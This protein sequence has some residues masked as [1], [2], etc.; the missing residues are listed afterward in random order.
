MELTARNTIQPLGER[1]WVLIYA[2]KIMH[3]LAE[4]GHEHGVVRS[5]VGADIWA[6]KIYVHVTVRVDAQQMPDS[7]AKAAADAAAEAAIVR[8]TAAAG[9]VGTVSEGPDSD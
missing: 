1:R 5:L 3:D 9:C 4:N 8:A 6:G 2:K 7:E